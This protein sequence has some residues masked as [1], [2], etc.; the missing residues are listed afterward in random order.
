MFTIP[1]ITIKDYVSLISLISEKSKKK[2]NIIMTWINEEEKKRIKSGLTTVLVRNNVVFKVNIV[3]VYCYGKV[4]LSTESDDYYDIDEFNWFNSREVHP[5]SIP[6]NYD[7]N[8]HTCKSNTKR[9]KTYDTT[10]PARLVQYYHACL[11]K[12]ERIV[13]FVRN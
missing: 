11:G 7:Y 10:S 3:D 2:A 1:M 9:Y 5:A 13:I 6:A 4:D 8:T 12:P